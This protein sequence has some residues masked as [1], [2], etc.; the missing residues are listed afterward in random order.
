MPA[1]V[2]QE[3]F[4]LLSRRRTAVYDEIRRLSCATWCLEMK[5]R[6]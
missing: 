4:L 6:P 1:H 5:A 3:A 2:V